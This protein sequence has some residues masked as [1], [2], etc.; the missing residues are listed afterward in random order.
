MEI[1]GVKIKVEN[2]FD[3]NIG[4]DKFIVTPGEIRK[5]GFFDKIKSSL[6]INAR[7]R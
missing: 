3:N 1:T 5:L 7:K 6:F 2:G 4:N